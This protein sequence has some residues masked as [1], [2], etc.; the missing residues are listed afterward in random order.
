MFSLKSTEVTTHTFNFGHCCSF[1]KKQLKI[2]ESNFEKHMNACVK[3]LFIIWLFTDTHSTAKTI[4]Y[5]DILKY[6]NKWRV[7]KYLERGSR[8][9]FQNI[10]PQFAWKN[11]RSHE[12]PQSV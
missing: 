2:H 12:N 7:G 5:R 3:K 4:Y 10:I 8:N 1:L 9:P 11:E 6:D